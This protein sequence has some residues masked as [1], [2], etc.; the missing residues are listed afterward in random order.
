Y[1]SKIIRR[2]ERSVSSQVRIS[3]QFSAFQLSAFQYFRRMSR[4]DPVFLRSLLINDVFDTIVFAAGSSVQNFGDRCC[5]ARHHR[6]REKS[7]P[8]TSAP[9]SAATGG[10]LPCP[11]HPAAEQARYSRS[12]P[13]VYAQ[14]RAR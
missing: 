6:F 5:A 2:V 11:F 3:F 7:F 14:S 13:L 4:S 9:I 1:N 10:G 12:L 8:A